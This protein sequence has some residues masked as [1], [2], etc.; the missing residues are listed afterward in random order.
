M[1]V[2]WLKRG[3]GSLA[4]IGLVLSLAVLAGKGGSSHNRHLLP[5]PV[6]V[7]AHAIDHFR[8]GDTATTR[9]G[10]FE[11]IGGLELRGAHANFGGLSAIRLTPDGQRFLAVTDTGD[12]L[13]GSI[14][15]RD[16]RPD[17]LTGVTIAPTL[18]ANGQR[19]KDIGLWDSESIALD[20]ERAYVGIERDHAILSFAIGR[21]GVRARGQP[22]PLPAFV[23]NWPDN[24]GIEALGILPRG[25]P[26]AGRLIGLS[27]RSG[28]RDE[29]TEGF[30]MKTD[31]SEAF[32]FRLV[33]SDGFDITD[34][35]FLPGGD[36]IV[37]ERYFTPIRGV[38]MRLRRVKT[39]AIQPDATVDG[40]VI[41]SADKAYHIDNMEGLS[42]TLN[43]AGET[44][45]TL[46]SDDNFSV[47]QRTLLLQFRWLER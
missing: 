42:I 14:R 34:L 47:A 3:L 25:T 2:R 35:D 37:L 45:F 46:I 20:S 9:F 19:A 13:E 28:G 12:W 32:R 11:F 1:M 6:A 33:R 4:T 24:R 10:Q 44:I 43:G 36:L 15:T 21:D 27:E 5:E 29:P 40:E 31:G 39:A 22:I 26:Y 41:L 18:G 7:T 8:I 23:S 38:A 17:G 16:G 30:V